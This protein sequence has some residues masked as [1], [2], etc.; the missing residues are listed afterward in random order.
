M[1]D[2]CAR[3]SDNAPLAVHP[4]CQPTRCPPLNN[5]DSSRFVIRFSLWRWPEYLRGS[6]REFFRLSIVGRV[7][8]DTPVHLGSGG[9][10][11]R[12]GAANKHRGPRPISPAGLKAVS[13]TRSPAADHLLS[14]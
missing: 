2:P 12:F 4:S 5:R 6:L 10:A 14:S 3:S 13:P 1:V 8:R 9:F 11:S 7:L